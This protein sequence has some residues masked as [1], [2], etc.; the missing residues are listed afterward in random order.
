MNEFIKDLK[1]ARSEDVDAILAFFETLKQ[2]DETNDRNTEPKANEPESKLE[3]EN[4][5]V[6]YFE[7][8]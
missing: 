1:R 5:F 2:R 6:L 7:K 4:K 8:L 3:N